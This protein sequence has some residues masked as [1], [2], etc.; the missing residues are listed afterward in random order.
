MNKKTG[1]RKWL[2]L[3]LAAGIAWTGLSLPGGAAANANEVSNT[4]V[5]TNAASYATP[6]GVEAHY[7][8][9]ADRFAPVIYQN[10]RKKG[11]F[12]AGYLDNY[13]YKIYADYLTKVNYDGDWNGSNNWQNLDANKDQLGAYVYYDVKETETHYYIGYYTYYPMDDAGADGDRHE[14]DMEGVLVVVRKGAENDGMGVPM[15]VVLEG[16]GK[17]YQYRV[18][19]AGSAVQ[20]SGD[21]IDG[22]IRMRGSHPEVFATSNGG[23]PDIGSFGHNIKK[24]DAPFNSDFTNAQN[25]GGI[26]Y[27]V[28]TDAQ[29]HNNDTIYNAYNN[30]GLPV[31]NY[32]KVTYKAIPISEL[33]D[34]R[35]EIGT[36]KLFGVFGR[37][38]G[39]D[40]AG[41]HAANAPWNWGYR[42]EAGLATGLIFYDPARLIQYMLTNLGNYSL[43]YVKRDGSGNNLPGVY[44]YEHPNGEGRM[45]HIVSNVGDLRQ[46][47]VGDD[48][49]T[50][51]KVIGANYQTV[52]CADLLFQ[53]A[54][55][56]NIMTEGLTNLSYGPMD[57]KATSVMVNVLP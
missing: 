35:L 37:I 9:V 23:T 28:G 48:S 24:W 46:G 14:N 54:F 22:T 19:G 11:V 39:D 47:L 20:N 16:H 51:V 25:F 53:G 8:A 6:A 5:T 57:N 32:S 38:N 17:L 42:P 30:G 1:F 56:S 31:G 43:R 15:L 34:K 2:P 12:R 13:N 10:V 29:I 41:E 55:S 7:Q 27:I 26:E 40:G 36:D 21:D 4:T 45:Q 50:S 18:D 44:L 3:G 49:I 33:W 52:L